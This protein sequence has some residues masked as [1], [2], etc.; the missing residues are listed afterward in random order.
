[1]LNTLDSNKEE[2]IGKLEEM[3]G[4]GVYAGVHTVCPYKYYLLKIDA[5][6]AVEVH[7]YACHEH[8]G[9]ERGTAVA[10]EW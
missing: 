4:G 2:M 9:N 7:H 6:C 10:H 5:P 1:L 8:I 3:S